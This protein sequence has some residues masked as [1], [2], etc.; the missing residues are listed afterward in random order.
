MTSRRIL[1]RVI[2]EHLGPPIGEDN[3]SSSE[4]RPGSCHPA[5]VS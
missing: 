1:L 3:L 2:L 5:S 4:D